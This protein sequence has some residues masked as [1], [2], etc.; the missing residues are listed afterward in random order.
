M[1]SFAEITLPV[2]LPV[3]MPVIFILIEKFIFEDAFWIADSGNPNYTV[4]KWQVI[5]SVEG[6]L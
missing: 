5:A 3:T 2:S 4:Q 6:I 1:R